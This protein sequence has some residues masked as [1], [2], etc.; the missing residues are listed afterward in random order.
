MRASGLAPAAAFR[1][2]GYTVA[3]GDLGGEPATATAAHLGAHGYPLDITDQ[4]SA[5]DFL[6][7]VDRA[8][9]PLDV[10]V[11]NAGIMPTGRFLDEDDTM[12]DRINDINIKGVQNGSKLAA[13]RFAARGHGHIVNI[14]SLAGVTPYP[15]L[16]TYC[17][18]KH[19]VLGFTDSLYSELKDTG[20]G[21]SSVLPAI[22]RTELSAG[23][24]TPAWLEGM[25]T[26]DPEEVALGVVKAV[27]TGKPRVVVPNRTGGMLKTMGLLSVPARLRMAHLF[28]L[29]VTFLEADP[30]TRE[31]YHRRITGGD[32]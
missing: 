18:T 9:G 15:G 14:A 6:A 23:A 7:E 27:R 10:L 30:A 29:D 4:T 31:K 11:D 24:K 5:V 32:Q 22:V 17:G 19:F 3:T 25:T 12:T 2:A 20:V 8:H 21:V 16:A 13:K 1:T 26:V 28:K